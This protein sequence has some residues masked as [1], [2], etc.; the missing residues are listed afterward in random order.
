MF[1]RFLDE[2]Y[3]GLVIQLPLWFIQLNKLEPLVNHIQKTLAEA[4][5]S[6]MHPDYRNTMYELE[7]Y[8]TKA[9]D[10]K[11]K[12]AQEEED[13][14]HRSILWTA[15]R[16]KQ[17][18]QEIIETGWQRWVDGGEM[19]EDIQIGKLYIPYSKLFTKKYNI[20]AYFKKLVK[21]IDWKQFV[22]DNHFT[23]C[24]S[25]IEYGCKITFSDM[26]VYS[27][28]YWNFCI[29]YSVWSAH[30]YIKENKYGEMVYQNRSIRIKDG[31]YS[32]DDIDLSLYE[33]E[34][35]VFIRRDKN[36]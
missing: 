36:V 25:Q 22:K 28:K 7:H 33:L 17:R 3:E 10:I 20:S 2:D 15:K 29:G 12:K 19:P 21:D 16:V 26:P 5:L 13:L 1:E 8:K 9:E 24:K 31:K 32:C 18:T 30:L 27:D 11:T 35:N 23:V 4:S 6:T 14:Y 34:G